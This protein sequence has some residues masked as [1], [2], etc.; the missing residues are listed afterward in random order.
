MGWMQRREAA[1]TNWVSRR[2]AEA[3]FALRVQAE[4][5]AL[6]ALEPRLLE[7]IGV[8]RAEAEVEARRSLSDTPGHRPDA[9]GGAAGGAL[10]ERDAAATDRLLAD[11]L[12]G[13]P[14]SRR[15]DPR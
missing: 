14:L 5:R 2:L 12:G 15:E 9:P 8:S 4:R 13:A 6:A 10:T 3:R 7:D 1:A 11:L